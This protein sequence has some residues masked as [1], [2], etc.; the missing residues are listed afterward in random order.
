MGL[1]NKGK[2]KAEQ[3]KGRAK[4]KLGEMTDQEDVENEGR[5]EQLKGEAKEKGHEIV[6]DAEQKLGEAEKRLRRD[7]EER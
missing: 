4:E 7:D 2:D 6:E 5:A 3:L 1:L